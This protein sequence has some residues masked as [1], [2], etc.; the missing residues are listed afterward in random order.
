MHTCTDSLKT[1]CLQHHSN[2]ERGMKKVR[3]KAGTTTGSDVLD[4]EVQCNRTELKRGTAIT[5]Y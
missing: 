4:H 5:V 3:N 1:E 2:I